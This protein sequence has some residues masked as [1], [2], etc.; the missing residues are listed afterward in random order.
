[1][2]FTPIKIDRLAAAPNGI[3]LNQNNEIDTNNSIIFMAAFPHIK[4][5]GFKIFLADGVRKDGKLI[6]GWTNRGYHATFL[7]KQAGVF[8]DATTWAHEIGHGLGLEGD[9]N[10]PDSQD[11]SNVMY[12]SRVLANGQPAPSDK[13]TDD[14]CEKIRSNFSKMAP[15]AEVTFDQLNVTPDDTSKHSVLVSMPAT[16]QTTGVA[17]E[18]PE[19]LA[20]QGADFLFTRYPEPQQVEI[21]LHLMGRYPENENISA[22][23]TVL[24]DTDNDE[25]TGVS[26]AGYEGMNIAIVLDV[27]GRFPFT[28]DNEPLVA[29]VR[30]LVTAKN[31]ASGSGIVATRE[32]QYYDAEDDEV[33]VEKIR[34][35]IA[36]YVPLESLGELTNTIGASLIS[37][38]SSLIAKTAKFSVVTDMDKPITTPSELLVAGGQSITLSGEL[39]TP[40]STVQVFWNNNFSESTH[41]TTTDS[42]GSFSL[43]FSVPKV[44]PGNYVVDIIDDQGEVDIVVLTVQSAKQG[45]PNWIWIAAGVV[46]AFCLVL[47]WFRKR[48]RTR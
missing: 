29:T 48:K 39:F 43:A 2:S 12:K 35:Y 22:T 13:F 46:V 38:T 3:A 24:L 21:L 36:I 6:D 31:I 17:A 20:V 8:G 23:Y 1:M 19:Y 45:W 28:T 11:P 40:N 7:Q 33:V 16:D 30:D 9:G 15:V 44:M 37:S 42:T 26:M 18:A 14:Q 27:Q 10:T 41:S 34:D 25:A 47:V 32:V 5:G 4:H